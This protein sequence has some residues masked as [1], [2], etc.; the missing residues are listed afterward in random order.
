MCGGQLMGCGFGFSDVASL[1]FSLVTNVFCACQDMGK[2]SRPISKGPML[3][4][5]H[6]I[7]PVLSEMPGIQK[8]MLHFW[9][10]SVVFSLVKLWGIFEL[11]RT[12]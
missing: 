7:G 12:F 2:A 11:L 9:L 3:Y 10:Q 4:K 5:W 1:D 6:E 8:T